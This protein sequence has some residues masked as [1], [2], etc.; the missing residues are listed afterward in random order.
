VF[1]VE[2]E[3]D[4]ERLRQAAVLLERENQKLVKQVTELTRLLLTAQGKDKAQLELRLQALE[5]QL[6]KRNQMLF[7]QSSERGPGEE[8]K[9]EKSK[10]PQKGHGPKEQLALPVSITTHEL[11]DADKVCPKC[12]LPLSAW[13]NQFEESEEVEVVT[14]SFVIKKHQRQKYLCAC[15]CIET[16]L[17]PKKLFAGARYS[18][19]FA[20]E[21]AV[22][23]YLDHL[24]LERQARIMRREGLDVDS[25][26]LW[27]QCERL[28]RWLKP[29]MP[30]LHAYALEH[31][32]LG[33]DETTWWLM[34]GRGEGRGAS[35]RWWL[36]TVVCPNAIYFRMDEHR[37][38]EAAKA[39]LSDYK[40]ILMCDGLASY[41]KFARANGSVTLVQ[42]WAH[43]RR[44]FFEC[45]GHEPDKVARVLGLINELF[46]IEREANSGPPSMRAALRK[47][48]SASVIDDID[49]WQKSMQALP[50][51]AF[52]K[53]LVY[54]R[55][56]WQ[57]LT[58]F[59]GDAR[60]PLHNN[61][62]ERAIRGP[63]VGRKNFRGCRS[64]RGLEVAALFYSLIESAKAN[65]IDPKHYLRIAVDAAIDGNEIPL[66]HQLKEL[67]QA[68]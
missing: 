47:E 60:I 54:L 30:K 8:S 9:N 37:S 55:E 45:E 44:A 56:R 10:A 59:L 25:Q 61:A 57:A 19:D 26:T 58:L 7:G 50:Q 66:P 14:R 36:W 21:V 33:A 6:E 42:C 27:D 41:E 38:A 43:V 40:G 17:G 12:A 65:G 48:K 52:G 53:A 29:A 23:K 63:V 67:A 18:I 28:A 49:A 11:C 34:R 24:P 46:R 15:G 32:V 20:I 4:I 22:Q 51:S 2:T 1:S 13:P 39:V 64:K 16:A 62:S 3:K 5:A 68:A 31:G 35:E